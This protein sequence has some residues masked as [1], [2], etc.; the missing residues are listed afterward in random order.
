MFGLSIV[1]HIRMEFGHTAQ[2]YT[3]HAEAAERLAGLVMKLR[4]TMLMLLFAT[5]V[6]AVASILIPSRN[7]EISAAIASG[8]ALGAYVVQVAL[9][10]E[11]RVQAHRTCAH[12]LLL[13][14]ERYRS[15]LAECHDGIIEPPAL[16]RRRDELIDQVHHA[17]EQGFPTD[18]PAFERERLGGAMLS[19]EVIDKLLPESLRRSP[20]GRAA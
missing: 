2:N 8:L 12:R 10:L 16:L 20:A 6:A 17:Y 7:F 5:A 13:A 3:V 1:D 18:H 9:G 19:D 4:V 15:L 11:T 14:C